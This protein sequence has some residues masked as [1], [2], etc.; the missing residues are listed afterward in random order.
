MCLLV[1]CAAFLKEN[2]VLGMRADKKTI[3]QHLSGSL[4]LVTAQM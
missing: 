3:N 4:M 2:L 1:E